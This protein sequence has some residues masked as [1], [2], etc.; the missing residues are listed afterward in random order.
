MIRDLLKA[1]ADVNARDSR[2]L[3]ALTFAVA[4]D[5]QNAQAVRA[6][7]EGGANVNVP[8]NTGETP[9]DWAEK[10][11]FP[12]VIAALKQAGAKHGVPYEA[13]QRPDCPR[14]EPAV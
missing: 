13:P 14:P 5:H 11:G 8:D 3:P 4:A 9:L 10:F 12:E 2:G 7:I 6:L 1:G